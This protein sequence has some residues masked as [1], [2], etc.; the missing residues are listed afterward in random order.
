MSVLVREFQQSHSHEWDCYLWEWELL[1][2]RPSV[3][4]GKVGPAMLTEWSTRLLWCEHRCMGNRLAVCWCAGWLFHGLSLWTSMHSKNSKEFELV[5]GKDVSKETPREGSPHRGT[6][7]LCPSR[8]RHTTVRPRH[9][10]SSDRPPTA[11][12]SLYVDP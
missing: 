10:S 6:G 7:I 3:L 9:A 2:C 5:P 4:G 8:D 12:R 1:S 11:R